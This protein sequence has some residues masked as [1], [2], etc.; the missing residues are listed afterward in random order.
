M[1]DEIEEV[2]GRSMD[3][4]LAPSIYS[5][6]TGMTAKTTQS[7][8]DK[9]SDAQVENERLHNELEAAKAAVSQAPGVQVS[10][11]PPPADPVQTEESSDQ[12]SS[13][14]MP[15][16]KDLIAEEPPDDSAQDSVS[17][18]L[19]DATIC[20]SFAMSDVGNG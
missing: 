10:E 4:W 5:E 16:E 7:T 2:D 1:D 9:L 20:A 17:T 8:R 15:P 3:S 6:I 18:D 14:E 11:P 13:A 19:K 12:P